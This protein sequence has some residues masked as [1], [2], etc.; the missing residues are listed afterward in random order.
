M[1][2]D[3]P[4]LCPVCGY[5]GHPLCDG[6]CGEGGSW[7]CK[8]E[9]MLRSYKKRITELEKDILADMIVRDGSIC[10]DC[11][12]K[13]GAEW[14]KGHLATFSSGQCGI[15]KGETT[16]CAVSDWNWPGHSGKKAPREF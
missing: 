10:P 6:Y 7:V 8:H 3:N 16:T 12:M 14:P 5:D 13:Y 11:A 9:E 4:F 15:C 1:T 2:S